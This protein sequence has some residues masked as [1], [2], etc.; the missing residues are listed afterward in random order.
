MKHCRATVAATVTPG[1]LQPPS[2]PK[3]NLVPRL[4]R[5]WETKN[6]Q[7]DHIFDLSKTK[8]GVI[9]F[10]IP[11]S[12]SCLLAV[13]TCRRNNLLSGVSFGDHSLAKRMKD[14]CTKSLVKPQEP[15][16]MITKMSRRALGQSKDTPVV[17]SHNGWT[18]DE[19]DNIC[20][21]EGLTSR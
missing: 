5:K 6:G 8:V 18:R 16:E 1:V 20:V 17:L 3:R 10:L 19:C 7:G 12:R 14:G 11:W 2:H 13:R 15:R 21:Q 4:W 9:T